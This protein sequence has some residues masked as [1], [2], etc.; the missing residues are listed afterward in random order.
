M[1]FLTLTYGFVTLLEPSKDLKSLLVDLGFTWWVFD[2][3]KLLP[4][5]L[6]FYLSV[7]GYSKN[8]TCGF[9]VLLE[10]FWKIKKLYLWICGFT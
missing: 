9:V 8:F 3:Q 6:W 7:F 4:V 10:C 5:D 1:K 2:N